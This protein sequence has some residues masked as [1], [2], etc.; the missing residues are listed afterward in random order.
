MS[1]CWI[2]FLINSSHQLTD[3]GGFNSSK[4]VVRIS[5]V[6]KT[7]QKKIFMLLFWTTFTFQIP[8]ASISFCFFL[9]NNITLSCFWNVYLLICWFIYSLT[10]G[11]LLSF[12][13]HA[14]LIPGK[15]LFSFL[16]FKLKTLKIT[17]CLWVAYTQFSYSIWYFSFNYGIFLQFLFRW[18][19]YFAFS[20][21]VRPP[22][23]IQFCLVWMR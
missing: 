2:K 15:N 21:C 18:Y 10:S 20:F 16:D 7:K 22:E 23:N 17:T 19:H 12:S 9:L 8:F 4:M 3:S 1:L 14:Q 5:F 13:T 6:C 11:I